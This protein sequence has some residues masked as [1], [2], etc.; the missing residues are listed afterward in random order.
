MSDKER[1]AVKE[2]ELAVITK[3]KVMYVLYSNCVF[4]NDFLT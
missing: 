4:G 1:I 2:S 3:A